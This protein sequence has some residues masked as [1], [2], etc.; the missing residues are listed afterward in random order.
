MKVNIPA[1]LVHIIFILCS[2]LFLLLTAYMEKKE[3]VPWKG[4]TPVLVKNDVPLD[5]LIE[6]IKLRIGSKEIISEETAFIAITR[7]SEI[8][9]IRIKDIEQ[10]LDPEDPRADPYIKNIQKYFKANPGWNVIFIATDQSPLWFYININNLCREKGY[11]VVM[12]GIDFPGKIILLILFVTFIILFMNSFNHVKGKLFTIINTVPWFYW[13]ILAGDLYDLFC[14]FII[15][16]FWFQFANEIAGYF[17]ERL[18]YQWKNSKLLLLKAINYAL[19]CFVVI[20]FTLKRE[21]AVFPL[22]PMFANWI[23]AGGYFSLSLFYKNKKKH[24]LFRYLSFFPDTNLKSLIKI[25]TENIAFIF[26]IILVITL[27]PIYYFTRSELEVAEL[28]IP[29]PVYNN[30]YV[31]S[32][33][34][35]LTDMNENNN[36]RELPDLTEFL[37]HL[38]FQE[39]IY[40]GAVYSIGEKADIMVDTYQMTSENKIFKSSKPVKTADEWAETVLNSLPE[41]SLEG[42]LLRQGRHQQFQLITFNTIF[43][44]KYRFW[45]HSLLLLFLL[46]PLFIFYFYLTPAILNSIRNIFLKRK[47]FTA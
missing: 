3:T 45:S 37:A 17:E 24:K 34:K 25:K 4:Y 44:N 40:Y 13:L 28:Y 7:F 5:S 10:R 15:Y 36:S 22:V 16:P 39:Q 19:A 23:F 38:R 47:L 11:T 42:M 29:V 6:A 12:P 21:S 33:I 41:N 18:I 14:F 8:E 32:G 1:V 27:I 31:K 26:I 43:K 9:K 2:G 30:L 46:I 20:G 35:I